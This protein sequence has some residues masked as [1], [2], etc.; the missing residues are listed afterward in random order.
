M[1]VQRLRASILHLLLNA[2]VCCAFF[3]PTTLVQAQE[4]PRALSSQIVLR[5]Q[6][7][8]MEGVIS[9]CPV[10]RG[11]GLV[12][13]THTKNS[14]ALYDAV[15]SARVGYIAKGDHS[16]DDLANHPGVHPTLATC[17]VAGEDVLEDTS[18]DIVMVLP[19][20]D[21]VNAEI[22]IKVK[23]PTRVERKGDGDQATFGG[24]ELNNTVLTGET[25]S[26][27][28]VTVRI[29][30]SFGLKPTAGTVR[31]VSNPPFPD[32]ATIRAK[33][34]AEII[35][36]SGEQ[37]AALKTAGAAAKDAVRSNTKP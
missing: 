26:G 23:G 22:R 21:G 1:T 30:R 34:N 16:H 37:S 24:I 20:P 12:A 9:G 7:G 13:E 25:D 14:V 18:M 10:Y 17:F 15:S 2:V 28:P 31:R 3:A 36:G 5:T 27:V 19:T 6:D 32:F 8:D 11:T 29:G 4:L 35:L 33:V